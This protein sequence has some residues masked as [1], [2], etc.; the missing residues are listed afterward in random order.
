MF[1]KHCCLCVPADGYYNLVFVSHCNHLTTH[2]TAAISILIRGLI[3]R[4]IADHKIPTHGATH[5]MNYHQQCVLLI[6]VK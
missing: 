2:L 3:T 6:S 1:T 4:Q 5:P